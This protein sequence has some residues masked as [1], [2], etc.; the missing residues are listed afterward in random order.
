MRAAKLWIC[1]I[2]VVVVCGLA[3]LPILATAGTVRT[4]AGRLIVELNFDFAPK[5]LPQTAEA[6]IRFW[7]SEKMRTKDGSAPPPVTH[8]VFE[9]NKNG[10]VDTRGLP[11]C[12]RAKLIATTVAQAR[13]TCPDAIIG[14]GLGEGI[15][16]FP[17]QAP[18]SVST[19]ITFFNAPSIGGDPTVI[20]HAHLNVPA[21]TTYLVTF[22]IERIHEGPLGYRVES[23]IP[24]I[25][26]GYGSVT[27]F[28]FRLGRK[29]RFAGRVLSYL[30]ARCVT[31][32]PQLLVHGETRFVDG[33]DLTGSLFAAC[34][35]RRE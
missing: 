16:S 35:I 15:I 5:A 13:K 24:K 21:P 20:V 9:F 7:G 17:E 2:A 6:P 23:D 8:L 4:I 3:A 28:R 22:R 33:T 14:E 18:I 32:L 10:S 26:G 34:R 31:P 27:E 25:A 29:W 19:P 30:N 11:T 1:G 12:A